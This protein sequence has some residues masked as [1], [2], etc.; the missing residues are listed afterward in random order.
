MYAIRSYYEPAD[1][2]ISGPAPTAEET[3]AEAGDVTL[4]FEDASL[5]E[6]IRVVFEEILKQNYL[7]DPLVKGTVTLHTTYPVT[8]DAVLPIVR[9]NFV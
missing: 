5:R 6:F 4:N 1:A 7:I 3:T 2:V 9:N 8:Q